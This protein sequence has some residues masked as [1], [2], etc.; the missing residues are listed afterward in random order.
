M[1]SNC[2][3]YSISNCSIEKIMNSG[4]CFRISE[5]EKGYY[6]VL[7]RD[8][9]CIAI[10]VGSDT[11]ISCK[12]DDLDYWLSYFDETSSDGSNLDYCNFEKYGLQY[13]NEFIRKSV[14][15][16]LGLR[17]LNQDP[18]ECLISF[19]ISQRKSIPAIRSSIE[20]LCQRYGLKKS[21]L[22]TEYYT[23]PTLDALIRGY[24][25]DGYADCSLG[26]RDS[27]IYETCKALVGYDLKGVSKL[28]YNEALKKLAEFKGVGVKVA[29]CTLLYSLGFKNAFPRDVW[30]NRILVAFFDKDY[31]PYSDFDGV[32]GLI[33]LYMFYFARS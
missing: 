3:Q 29:N 24:E 17:L 32:L 15:Y 20:K 16:G 28:E 30:I 25:T 33:Q 21:Y 6:L 4:Q 2:V 18:F 9:A 14:E 22:G 26:Y 11:T 8:L 5:I 23:F 12:N 31:F 7:S 27:Y 13:D 1:E 19:I 10:Q